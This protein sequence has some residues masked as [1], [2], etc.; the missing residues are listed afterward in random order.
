MFP[1]K[2]WLGLFALGLCCLC[3]DCC[4]HVVSTWSVGHMMFA[5]IG[6]FHVQSTRG[7]MAGGTVNG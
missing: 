4:L 7:V 5:V 1:R 6:G 3:R 2:A